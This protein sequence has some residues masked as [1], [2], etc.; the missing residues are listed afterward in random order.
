MCDAR[1]HGG[2]GFPAFPASQSLRA[3]A[4]HADRIQAFT[5]ENRAVFRRG[6]RFGERQ[7]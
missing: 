4:K 5:T 2:P 6:W 1:A 3:L 7:L